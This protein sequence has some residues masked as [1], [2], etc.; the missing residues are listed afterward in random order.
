M[1]GYGTM[2]L[3][4]ESPLASSINMRGS[5]S[6]DSFHYAQ[7]KPLPRLGLVPRPCRARGASTSAHDIPSLHL[8]TP[9]RLLTRI[10]DRAGVYKEGADFED[11][12]SQIDKEGRGIGTVAKEILVGLDLFGI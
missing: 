4:L 1:R 11:S 8:W 9:W 3:Q 6:I 10:F 7:P 12:K 5:D 2:G